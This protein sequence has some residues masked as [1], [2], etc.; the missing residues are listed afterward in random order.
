MTLRTFFHTIIFTKIIR[1]LVFLLADF[2]LIKIS[3]QVSQIASG[4]RTSI[5]F[6]CSLLTTPGIPPTEVTTIGSEQPLPKLN[7][8]N[9]HAMMAK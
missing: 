1:F 3:I 5:K 6:T 8:G 4:F 7:V 9:L 2:G